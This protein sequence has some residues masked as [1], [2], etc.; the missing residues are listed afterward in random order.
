[1]APL[2][3]GK[4]R[5]E[6]IRGEDNWNLPNALTFSRVLMAPLIAFLLSDDGRL[7]NAL[8]AATVGTAA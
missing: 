5:F 3:P 8:A 4:D 1:M 6:M 7:R 2:S